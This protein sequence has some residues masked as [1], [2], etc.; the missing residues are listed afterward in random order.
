MITLSGEGLIETQDKKDI[1]IIENGLKKRVGFTTESLRFIHSDGRN[2]IERIQLLSSEVLGNRKGVTVVE[3]AAFQP[4]SFTDYVDEIMNLKAEYKNGIVNI[5]TEAGEVSR[6]DA[7]GCFDSF[8]VELILRA[9][10]LEAGYSAA[11]KAFNATIKAVVEINLEVLQS[12]KIRK[13]K[14]ELTDAWKVKTCFGETVQYYWVDPVNKELLKQSS[15][16]GK[17]VILEF[18]R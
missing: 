1:F 2:A 13:S 3:K 10:P 14:D 18:R 5:T 8:S 6:F 16:I 11:F 15:D 9:L 7:T 4:I 12:E 17:G